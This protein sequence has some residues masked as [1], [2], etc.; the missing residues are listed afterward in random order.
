MEEAKS[1]MTRT[2]SFCQEWRSIPHHLHIVMVNRV[3]AFVI[4]YISDKDGKFL[5]VLYGW[6]RVSCLT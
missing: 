3:L 5:L 6:T 2:F 4:L 1:K